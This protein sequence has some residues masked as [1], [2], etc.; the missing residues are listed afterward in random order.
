MV[1]ILDF[2]I[3]PLLFNSFTVNLAVL[4]FFLDKFLVIIVV[5]ITTLLDTLNPLYE[6]VIVYLFGY[7]VSLNV[8]I[9]F[10]AYFGRRAAT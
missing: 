4:A 10:L 3:L 2:K 6:A 8:A 1:A 5:L 7:C 9:P